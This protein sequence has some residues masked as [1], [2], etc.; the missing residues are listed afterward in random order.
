MNYEKIYN[1]IIEKAKS[2]VE[3]RIAHKKQGGYYE[4]HHIVPKC[5]GGSN[6]KEN[7]V[8]LTAK[9]HFICHRLLCEIFTNEPKLKYALW[10]MCNIENRNQ[11]RYTVS[12]RIYERIKSEHSNFISSSMKGKVPWNKGVPQTEETKKKISVGNKG[13]KMPREAVERA[14]QLRKGYIHSEETRKKISEKNTGK[15]RSEEFK[16]NLSKLY[17]GRSPHNKG[18][19]HTEDSK[20]RI[21]ETMK[22]KNMIPWNKGKQWDKKQCPYCDK[23]VDPGNASQWHFDKC[24]HKPFN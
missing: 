5:L 7:L 6:E 2:D 16:D 9:E 11:T 3:R 19:S 8:L 18:K 24:K 22:S 10:M 1:R 20:K 17:K 4:G 23:L 15:T 21:S 14:K 13:K 12:S